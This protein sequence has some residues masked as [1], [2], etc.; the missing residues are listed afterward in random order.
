MKPIANKDCCFN[1]V[2]YSKGD[3]IK[4]ETKEQLIK[5]NEIGYIEPLTMGE[6]Q[7]FG[8]K[9]VY[10]TPKFVVNKKTKKEE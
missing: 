6:I 5:L 2:F 8:Q 4:V 3:E 1:G 10:E 7:K 9:P